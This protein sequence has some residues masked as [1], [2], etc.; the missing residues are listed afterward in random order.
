MAP[1]LQRG[2]SPNVSTVGT[3]G[4]DSSGATARSA[5]VSDGRGKVCKRFCP[6]KCM[7]FC[8][9]TLARCGDGWQEEYH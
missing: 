9:A 6:T 8:F 2:V 1:G 3:L 7:G 4:V 5:Q